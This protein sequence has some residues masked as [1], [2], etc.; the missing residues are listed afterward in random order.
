MLYQIVPVGNV[1][2]DGMVAVPKKVATDYIKLAS[3]YQLKAL[4]LI[5]SN[6]APCDSKY[7]A[8]VLGCTEA[9]ATDFLEF[10]VEEGVLS[11]DGVINAQPPAESTAV[12]ELPKKEEVKAVK[13][14]EAIPVPKLNPSDIVT[15]CRDNREL[16]ELI[17][18]AQEVFGRTISHIEQ[19]LVINMVTYYGLPC[20]V[21]LVILEYYKTE[22]AKGRAI[23]TSY[24]GTMAKN[25]SEEGIVTLEAADERL[26]MLEA[27]DRLWSE[28][29]AV[30]GIKHRNPT[31][32]Q[33]E[34]INRWSEDFDMQ[35][36]TIAC[37]IMKENT[38]KP[39]LKYVDS[40]LKNWKKKGIFTPEAV[41]EEEKEFHS[42]KEQKNKSAID[43]T[44]DIDEINRRAMLNDNYDI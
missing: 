23:G 11:C 9:D 7:V 36:I 6:N 41:D 26:R 24:I 29:V 19:E 1:W 15:M 13:V 27:S 3:E 32:K 20:D 21:V 40:V 28:I 42:K 33:R 14:K 2:Q 22:K 30:S 31:I 10:W 16:T 39:T 4:L 44:Y 25:W 34:M 8:K 18:H 38:D 12:V 37:D 5:L 17:H 35:M 43:E